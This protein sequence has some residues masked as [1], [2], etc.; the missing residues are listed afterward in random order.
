MFA[1]FIISYT[2]NYLIKIRNQTSMFGVIS[3][4]SQMYSQRETQ[5]GSTGFLD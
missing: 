2:L 4:C 3:Q 1:P 5:I